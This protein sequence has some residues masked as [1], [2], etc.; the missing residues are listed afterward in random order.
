MELLDFCYDVLIRILEELDPG[1]LA[2]CAQASLAFNHF[3][4]GNKRLYKAHYLKNFDDPRIRPTDPEPTWEQALQRIIKCQKFLAPECTDAVKQDNFCFV[5]STIDTILYT[6]VKIDGVSKNES[7]LANYFVQPRNLD[8]FMYRSS[9]YKKAGTDGQKA[10]ESL[11]DRQLSA[12]LHCLHGMALGALGRRSLSTYPYARSRIYDLRNYTAKTRW[13]PFRA[14]GSGKVD[15]EM[16]ESIMIDIGYTSDTSC[17]RFMPYFRPTWSEPFFGITRDRVRANYPS[18]LPIEPEIPL[19]LR[20][21]YNVSGLW[22]RIVCFLGYN[23]L[24]DFNYRSGEIPDGQPREPIKIEENIRHIVMRLQVTDIVP[25]IPTD[26]Q[27]LPIVH[28]AGASKSLDISWD[29][30]ASSRIRG[31]VRLT[32]EGEVHWT[33][34]SIFSGGEER[35]RSEGI[36]VGGPNSKRGVTGTW[37]DKD[38]DPNGPVGPTAFWKMA[39]DS[40]LDLED[41]EESEEEEDGW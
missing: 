15:W 10:A 30:N 3:I 12:K 33:V 19:D 34:I 41:D 25:P 16:L 20:D 8:N 28:F 32:P 17:P 2:A 11:E 9:L 31:Q 23:D 27:D 6:A 29:P 4:K 22:H 36:Q 7:M 5:A 37:F 38:Y 13:G 18:T 24:Y 26:G 14:D 40:E 35:W 1:D 21:P 39:D